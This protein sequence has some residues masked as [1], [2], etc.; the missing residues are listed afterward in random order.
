MTTPNQTATDETHAEIAHP[1]VATVYDWIVPERTLFA[2]QRRYLTADLEGRVLDIGAGTGANFPHVAAADVEFH[3]IEPDPYMRRQA[4]DR[5]R[6]VGCAVDLRDGRAESLP[7]PDDA[8]DVVL[9]G[10]VFCTIADPDRAVDEVARVLKPG[11]QFRFLEHVHADGWQ[12]TGQDLLNPLWERVAGGCQ[13]N[14]ETVDR[15]VCHDAFS[16]DEIERLSIGIF[17]AKPMVRG[18]LS[19]RPVDGLR[20]SI[21][22][23]LSR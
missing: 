13:L 9:A 22:E 6:E 1:L 23:L 19:R 2:P 17:P 11:G 21:R 14:R 3:A 4:A 16:V 18:R 20:T 12:A 15:F 5:A 7:Y 8:F 10:L